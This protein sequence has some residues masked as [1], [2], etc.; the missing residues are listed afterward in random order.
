[1]GK[2]GP[3][4]WRLILRT[5]F[6]SAAL[7][8]LVAC[9]PQISSPDTQEQS[10]LNEALEIGDSKQILLNIVRERNGQALYFLRANSVSSSRSGSQSLSGSASGFDP[11]SP[12]IAALNTSGNVSTANSFNVSYQPLTGDDYA[13][14]VFG[15]IPV[16]D[17]VI[18]AEAGSDLPILMSMIF[19]GL[20]AL[21]FDAPETSQSDW[22][23]AISILSQFLETDRLLIE[24]GIGSGSEP[25][26][27]AYF[28]PSVRGTDDYRRLMGILNLDPSL[29]EYSIVSSRREFNRGSIAVQTR[30]FASILRLIEECA[31]FQRGASFETQ[32][33]GDPRCVRLSMNLEVHEREPKNILNHVKYRDLWYAIPDE[34][35]TSQRV[36]GSLV[37]LYRLLSADIDEVAPVLNVQTIQTSSAPPFNNAAP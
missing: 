9:A 29:G 5:A 7:A 15:R 35:V 28:R 31:S 14:R 34:D 37:N 1:M 25:A 10:S 23:A 36:F 21:H 18:L 8:A 17:I 22:Q 27:T 32:G 3:T 2:S 4:V 12:P 6:V 24:S 16:L 19:E 11:F 13:S 33:A 20:N 26:L 30:S